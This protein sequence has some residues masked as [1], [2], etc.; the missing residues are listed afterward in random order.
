MFI[1]RKQ[2]VTYRNSTTQYKHAATHTC[3]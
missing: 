1:D 3:M 2:Y